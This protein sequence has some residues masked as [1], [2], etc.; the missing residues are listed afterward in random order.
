MV[1]RDPQ[2]LADGAAVDALANIKVKNNHA[3]TGIDLIR[4]ME[5]LLDSNFGL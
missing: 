3:A 4:H 1:N 2:I 5:K